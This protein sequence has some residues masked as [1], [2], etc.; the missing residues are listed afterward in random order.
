MN[1]LYEVD[2]ALGQLLS[3]MSLL[4]QARYL[5]SIVLYIIV[6]NRLQIE[7]N[8]HDTTCTAL[9][10]YH[11]ILLIQHLQHAADV[12]GFSNDNR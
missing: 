3:E 2:S 8:I 4:F 11:S 1:S 9:H 5:I 10:I 12:H 6:G 7:I